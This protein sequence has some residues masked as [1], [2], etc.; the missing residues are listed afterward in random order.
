MNLRPR[1]QSQRV[2]V[3]SD[4][5]FVSLLLVFYELKVVYPVLQNIRELIVSIYELKKYCYM[6]GA[7]KKEMTKWQ[8]LKWSGE[9]VAK[10]LNV[11]MQKL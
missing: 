2:I 10:F 7:A 5:A 4:C 3:P 9:D 1:D 6:L 8:V 11:I